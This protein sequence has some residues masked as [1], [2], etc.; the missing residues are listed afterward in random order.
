[1]S[2][3]SK[4][5]KAEILAAYKELLA[6]QQAEVITAPIAKNTAVVVYRETIDLG[7]DI[8]KSAALLY[9]WISQ[10]IDTLR[11]PVLVRR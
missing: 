5:T 8:K 4:S 7:R 6:R 3:T 10:I 2:I 1:M 9:Q 11:Q